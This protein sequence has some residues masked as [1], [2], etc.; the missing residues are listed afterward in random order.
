[1]VAVLLVLVGC[2]ARAAAADVRIPIGGGA[3]IVINGDTMCTLTT[4]G[5]MPPVS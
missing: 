5:A 2:P 4:I 3:G 1:M